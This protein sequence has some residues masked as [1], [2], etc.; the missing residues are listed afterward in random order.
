MTFFA[1]KRV[2]HV[3]EFFDELSTDKLESAEKRFQV[4][5]VNTV[6]DVTTIA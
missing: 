5:V 2:S 4:E 3:R 6:I 1:P